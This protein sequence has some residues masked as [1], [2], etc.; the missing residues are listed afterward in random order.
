MPIPAMLLGAA[1]TGGTMILQNRLNKRAQDRAFEQNKAFW[2]ER[3]DKEAEYNSPVQQ[4]ARMQAAGLN[5][6][7]MYKSGAGGGGNVSSPS[8]QGKVAER[9]ELG[10]LAL[11]SA[12]VAKINEDTQKVKAEKAYIQSKTE[13]QGTTNQILLEDLTMK[14]IDAQ[15]KDQ[16]TKNEVET[17]VQNALKAK[18]QAKTADQEQQILENVYLE[19]SKKGIDLRKGEINVLLQGLFQGGV[20]V[21][22]KINDILQDFGGAGLMNPGASLLNTFN[23]SK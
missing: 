21:K 1:A 10:Q 5:P 13:G 9:Y 20:S 7:L 16:R 2:Q 18:A 8:A 4:K 17:I 22:N 15:Y 23:L 19:A 6:A 12:Q 3:F 11:Q 14:A